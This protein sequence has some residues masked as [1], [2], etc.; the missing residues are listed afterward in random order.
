MTAPYLLVGEAPNAATVGVPELW[1]RPDRSGE[2]HS[3]NRLL[4][5]TG[6]TAGQYMR[7][8]DRTNLL[9]H[10]PPPFSAPV[11][12]ERAVALL[13]DAR[14]KRYRGIV[15]LG[16]RT[17][18][19]FTQWHHLT[20]RYPVFPAD[21]TLLQWWGLGR[22]GEFVPAAVCPHPSGL[23]QWWN[24]ERNRIVAKAFFANLL[25]DAQRC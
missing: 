12:R 16:Q 10:C 14:A 21:R 22:C 23:N 2:R 8:F 13:A 18:N 6:W 9:D 3:A 5:Y 17:A 15:L 11:A 19:A 7:T 4:G 1:L 20:G 25:E 24:D